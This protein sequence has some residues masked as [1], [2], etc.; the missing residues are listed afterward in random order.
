MLRRSEVLAERGAESVVPV[1]AQKKIRL[2]A[3]RTLRS[4]GQMQ[5]QGRAR[6]AHLF[7]ASMVFLR[8]LLTGSRYSFGVVMDL[9]R[10]CCGGGERRTLTDMRMG[11]GSGVGLTAGVGQSTG[12]AAT[13]LT[14]K[15]FP[16]V[17]RSLPSFVVMM[18]MPVSSSWA[19]YRRVYTGRTGSWAGCATTNL[20]PDFGGTDS[21]R[22][23]PRVGDC[24]PGRTLASSPCRTRRPS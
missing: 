9:S 16:L 10:L 21:E 15:N 23:Y 20:H 1:F 14:W 8:S 19:T 24:A 4:R 12:V 18:G 5:Q 6:C 2:S 3:L 11:A 13:H 22:L 17:K 7:T